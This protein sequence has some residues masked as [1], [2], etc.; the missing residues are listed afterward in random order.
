MDAAGAIFS[1]ALVFISLCGADQGE[2]FSPRTLPR[3]MK[4]NVQ[5]STEP[6]QLHSLTRALCSIARQ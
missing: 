6:G 1:V 2:Q 3:I 4:P 5:V